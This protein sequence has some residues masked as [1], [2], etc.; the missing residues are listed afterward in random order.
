MHD[1]HHTHPRPR[2]LHVPQVG[3]VWRACTNSLRPSET[4]PPIATDFIRR[5]RDKYVNMSA[6]MPPASMTVADP[7][8]EPLVLWLPK[9]LN[10]GA[11]VRRRTKGV[12]RLTDAATGR[13]LE[14]GR[15]AICLNSRSGGWVNASSSFFYKEVVTSL[16]KQVPSFQLH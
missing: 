6:G 5:C 15:G 4:P 1:T 16:Y 12:L 11:H 10:P 9:L 2:R 14:G 3:P 13:R 8:F 7:E